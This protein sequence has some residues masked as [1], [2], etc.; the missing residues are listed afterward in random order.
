MAKLADGMARVAD[1]IVAGRGQRVEF[2][3]EIKNATRRRRGDVRSQ[4]DGLKASRVRAGRELAIELRKKTS[5][6][7]EDVIGF[8]KRTRATRG[9]M[10]HEQRTEAAAATDQ[11]R[12]ETKALLGRFGQELAASQQHRQ[13]S[14]A[15]FMQELTSNVAAL[16]DGFDRGDRERATVVRERLGAYALDRRDALAAWAEILHETP[17]A[18]RNV[19]ASPRPAAPAAAPAHHAAPHAPPSVAPKAPEVHAAP[20]PS[21][22][23][24]SHR[25][26]RRGFEHGGSNKPYGGEQK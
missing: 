8:L 20:A 5:V 7:H 12:K 6:R 19:E 26:G 13:A 11:R 15:A 23:H 4:L 18:V 24:Q 9:R 10:A 14:A 22:D 2:A 17:A 21:P 25:S 3:T 16:L 1:G